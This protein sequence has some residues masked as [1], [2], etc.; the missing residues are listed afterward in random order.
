M[1]AAARKHRWSSGRKRAV[2]GYAAVE[3]RTIKIPVAALEQRRLRVRAVASTSK[4]VKGH[5]ATVGRDSEDCAITVAASK[6]G[7]AI[8][9]LIRSLYKALRI[10]TI[11]RISADSPAPV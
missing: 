2:A 3:R 8:K 4:G 7:S 1:C 10:G 5:G 11:K 6:P 9:A